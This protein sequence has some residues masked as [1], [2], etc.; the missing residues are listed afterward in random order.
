MYLQKIPDVELSIEQDTA[1]TPE[2]N[3]FYV[4]HRDVIVGA[5]RSL[6]GACKK[7][8]EILQQ[9]GFK[10]AVREEMGREAVAQQAEDDLLRKALYR[11]NSS[12][13]RPTNK[14]RV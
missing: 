8:A 3:K 6:K 7:Y 9:I 2:P 1:R 12:S 11:Y 10:P 14:R 4:I 5:Y 13:F